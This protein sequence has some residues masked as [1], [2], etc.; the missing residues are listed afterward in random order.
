VVGPSDAAK[1][2]CQFAVGILKAIGLEKLFAR[3]HPHGLPARQPFPVA[4]RGANIAQGLRD[5]K[6]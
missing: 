4:N 1:Q 2:H 6:Y 3:P 5:L